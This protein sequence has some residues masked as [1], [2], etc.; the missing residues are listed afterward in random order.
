MLL[1][2]AALRGACASVRVPQTRSGGVTESVTAR[3]AGAD[4]PWRGSVAGGG[5]S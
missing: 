2:A 1:S 5:G 3:A 4:I